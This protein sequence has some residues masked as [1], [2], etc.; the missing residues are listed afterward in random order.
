MAYLSEQF[1]YL[2]N[3]L[4]MALAAYNGGG[5]MRRRA[6]AQQELLVRARSVAS[7]ARDAGHALRAGGEIGCSHPEDAM[8]GVPAGYA[9]PPR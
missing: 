5:R 6:P 9:S 1:R 4:E 8:T 2:N 7:P 3:N